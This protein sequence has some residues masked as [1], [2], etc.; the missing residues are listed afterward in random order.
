MD[1]EKIKKD[2]S[3]EELLEFGIINLDKPSGPTSF[4]T[5]EVIK[6]KLDLKKMSHFGTLDP[7]VTGVLPIALNRACKLTRWFIKKDKT[8]VGIM[9]IHQKVEKEKLEE[10]M[11]KFIGIIKQVPPVK[12]SVKREERER[13]VYSWDLLE[14]KQDKGYALFK[15]KVEKGTYIRKLISD[16]GEKIGGAH[17]LELRRTK[18]GIFSEDDDNF[19]NLYDLDKIKENKE[20]LRKV[21]IPGEAIGKILPSIEVKEKNKKQLLTG[22]P[23]HKEDLKEDAK[24]KKGRDVAVFCQDQFIEVARTC[25][26]KDVIA[27]PEFVFN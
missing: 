6:R 5:A 7:K 8:Y 2:K 16:M 18:A 25:E 1:L 20:E 12:S 24:F 10:E 15:T 4:K 9:K 13:E 27:K 26:D 11:S 17:M 3:I 23:I 19:V 22:K 14:Y 21:I